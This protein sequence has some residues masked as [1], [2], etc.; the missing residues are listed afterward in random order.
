MN[1]AHKA[2]K[3][4]ESP[5]PTTREINAGLLAARVGV[6]IFFITHGYDKFFGE[7]GLAG[8]TGMLEGMGMPLA[9]L[10]AF[11]VAFAELFGGIAILLGVFTRFSAFW[12]SII[13]LVAFAMVK[14]FALG[15]DAGDLDVLA[16]GLT[17]ALF[18][19]GP[20]AHS[21]SAK[22]RS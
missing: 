19:M 7:M 21:L 1:I 18:F 6:A 12:L 20:G 4:I 2:L 9:G 13:S 17:V 8:F 15:M 3:F 5:E 11:L 10:F 22:L 14:G 16:L